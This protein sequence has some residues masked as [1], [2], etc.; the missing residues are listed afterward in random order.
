MTW[1]ALVERNTGELV[2]VGT[3]IAPDAAERFDV[4]DVGSDRPDGVWNPAT[5]RFDQRPSPVLVDRLGELEAWLQADPDFRAAWTVLLPPQRG[6]L[7]D[8][9]RR[10]LARAYGKRRFRDERERAE[11]G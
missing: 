1:V 9:L 5:R 4:I 3:V 2:S 7:Q 8:G 10:V 11:I 6:L